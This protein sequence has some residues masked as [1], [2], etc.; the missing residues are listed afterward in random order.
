MRNY[1]K[2]L[3]LLSLLTVSGQVQ[4]DETQSG[5]AI[6]V[7]GTE[8]A[9]HQSVMDVL[10]VLP[11]VTVTDDVV[12]VIGCGTAV[13]YIGNRKITENSELSNITADRIKEVEIKKHPGAEYDKS[14]MAVLVIRLKND[15]SEG[16]QL[17]NMLQLDLTHK[18]S[19]TDR[20]SLGWRHK[21]LTLRGYVGFE[22]HRMNISSQSFNRTYKD[23][24]LISE[25]S[26]FF[27]SKLKSQWIHA[28]ASMA[29]DFSIGHKLTFNY[30]LADKRID[31]FDIPEF[32]QTSRH[33]STQHDFALEYAGRWGGWDF[34]LG[35]NSLI[36]NANLDLCNPESDKKYV[37]KQYDVRTFAKAKTDLWKGSLNVGAEYQIDDMDAKL[38]DENPTMNQQD[39]AYGLS[40]AKHPDRT[41]GLFTSLSQTFGDWTIEAGVRYEYYNTSYKACS[42]DG[43]LQYLENSS[44]DAV[45]QILERYPEITSLL[46]DG[47][48]TYKKGMFFPSLKVYKKFGESRLSLEHTEFSIPPDFAITRLRISE[49]DV[50]AKKVLW[51]EIASAT[52][53]GFKHKWLDLALTFNH[54]DDPICETLNSLDQYNAPDYNALDFDV[55]LTPQIG[56]WTPML[57]ANFHKQWFDMQLAS[58]KDRLKKP[59]VNVEFYN[60]L[61]L[62]HD[63]LLR[64]NATWYSKGALRNNY[65]VKPDLCIDASVQK[66]LP[67]QGL[68]FLLSCYNLLKDSYS[69]Y[70]RYN[71]AYYGISE[72]SRDRNNRILSLTIQYKM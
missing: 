38:K 39:L 24:Q 61:S 71:Q 13:V 26:T 72:G 19:G 70:A 36:F 46:R 3:V 64:C 29:Y 57:H 23:K 56:V 27:H 55:T 6:V 58:G 5:Q 22:E 51:S 43:L 35:N 21:A 45:A 48:L 52:T 69:D 40:H 47:S 53:L 28:G 37:R 59:H 42:D 34:A 16:L 7:E 50:W 18:L 4:A 44:P 60:T 33:P 17:D 32:M 31:N 67:K 9:M 11:G 12:T 49:I 41:L 54:Y 14:V 15:E 10:R 68:T 63:W 30:S 2:P 20:F 25:G 62:P 8:M 66:T 65:Y 1:W